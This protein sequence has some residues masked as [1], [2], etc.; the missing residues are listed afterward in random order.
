MKKTI[1]GLAVALLT[2]VACAHDFE[3]KLH[4]AA[5]ATGARNTLAKGSE[6][7]SKAPGATFVSNHK[8]KFALAAAT[9]A[10]VEG[11]NW[12]KGKQ[13]YTTQLWN[14]ARQKS[15]NGCSALKAWFASK[16]TTPDTDTTDTDLAL[17]NM[18]RDV[19]LLQQGAATKEN[20]EQLQKQLENLQKTSLKRDEWL[21][22]QKDSLELFATKEEL[23]LY[24]SKEDGLKTCEETTKENT[25]LKQRVAALETT[26]EN[27][28]KLLAKTVET[29]QEQTAENQADLDFQSKL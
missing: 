22:S 12:Y 23:K 7:I 9:F 20:V 5:F 17:T 26:L 2:T 29:K 24:V 10:G 13:L 1:L 4:Y 15:S 8:I 21:K 6:I 3:F 28:Q 27:I 25:A 19:N 18:R 11:Y 16:K 14:W